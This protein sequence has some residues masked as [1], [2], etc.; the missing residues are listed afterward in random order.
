MA[1]GVNAVMGTNMDEATQFMGDTPPLPYDANE[2][3][4]T[5]WSISFFGP[6]LGPRVSTAYPNLTLPFPSMHGKPKPGAPQMNV[7]RW[8][9]MAMRAAGDYGFFCPVREPAKS[10]VSAGSAGSA[11]NAGHDVG[12]SSGGS[13]SSG[14]SSS[15]AS[16]AFMYWFSLTPAFSLNW[17]YAPAYG[18]FHGAEVPFVFGDPFEL[19][20]EGERALSSSMGCFWS[21][22][23]NTGNPNIPPATPT[24]N[25][26]NGSSSA[27]AP[28]SWPHYSY[29]RSSSNA[30]ENG[31]SLLRLDVPQLTQEVAGL[32]AAAC[33]LFSAHYGR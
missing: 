9:A 2:S 18:A 28:V 6:D 30:V 29:S 10:V 33:E 23:A 16:S 5:Q 11:G 24:G 19:S 26:G 3:Q 17:N 22:F 20:T 27:C 8:W 7:S 31:D 32:K 14:S 21:N 1:P 25:Q 15:S 12:G 13:S 4:F